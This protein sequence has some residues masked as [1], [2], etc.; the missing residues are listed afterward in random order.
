[1][2]TI[3]SPSVVLGTDA[4]ARE[5]ELFFPGGDGMVTWETADVAW[6]ASE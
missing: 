2:R 1:M 6:H 5:I 4:A 3:D